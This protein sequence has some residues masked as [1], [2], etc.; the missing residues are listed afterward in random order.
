M[1]LESSAARL[2]RGPG[3]QLTR[4]GLAAVAVVL[5]AACGDSGGSLSAPTTVLATTTSSGLEAEG[6]TSVPLSLETTTTTTTIPVDVLAELVPLEGFDHAVLVTRRADGVESQRPVLV[7]ATDGQRRQGLMQVTDL[8][9]YVG[10]AFVW[11][12][13]HSGSFWMRNTPMPLSIAF[14]DADGELVSTA[15]MEPCEDSPD[16]PI[17]PPAGPYV[18]AVEVPQGDLASLGIEEGSI[19]T[20]T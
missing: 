19:A 11:D 8:G 2:S 17:Y 12:A 1:P 4:L 16:C 6:H 14:I 9:G 5:A 10:M 15:D 7:A 13:P 18:L 3:Y 20:L